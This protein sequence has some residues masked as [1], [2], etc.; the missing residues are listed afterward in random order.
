MFGE[1]SINTSSK[2]NQ[3]ET[4]C[5]LRRSNL[6]EGYMELD[7]DT[8]TF[9]QGEE[10]DQREAGVSILQKYWRGFAPRDV[11][12]WSQ[13]IANSGGYIVAA[14]V[15]NTIAGILEAMRLDIGGDPNQVPATFEELT[16]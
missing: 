7:G 12:E 14:Y 13:R 5:K 3:I 15:G 1:K 9:R 10:I 8:L 6:A 11:C 2:I 4:L 16:A